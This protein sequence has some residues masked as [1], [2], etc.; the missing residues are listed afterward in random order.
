MRRLDTPIFHLEKVVKAKK[1]ELQDFTGPLDLI[2]HLLGKNKIEI[3]DI[4]V[5]FILDQYLDY[6]QKRKQMD[7]E[8]ASEFVAMAAHLVYIKTK[9]LLTTA[10]EEPPS[11]MEDLVRS[12]EQ[13][14]QGEDYENLKEAAKLL[15]EGY[16]RGVNCIVKGL[17]E[18]KTDGLSLLKHRPEDLTKAMER[19]L[20][21][22]LSRRPPPIRIF[23]TVVPKD[24]YPVE[25]KSS[26]LLARLTRSGSSRFLSLFR[27]SRSRSEIVATFIALL[28]L[29]RMNRI[30]LEDGEGDCKVLSIGSW[31]DKK[32]A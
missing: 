27:G 25:K 32:E 13:R 16:A 8:I 1:E 19:L 3:R 17:E 28:E 21:R 5:S 26:E 4:S 12:L 14:Q 29:C 2:L 7:L 30:H 31:E 22:T 6:L 24:P 9:M 23:E 20:A 10:N 18:R 15:G 11:E